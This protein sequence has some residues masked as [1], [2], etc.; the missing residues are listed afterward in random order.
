MG[1]SRGE[2]WWG[3]AVHKSASSY[4]PWLVVS[5]ESHPFAR[6]ECICLALTTKQHAQSISI[7]AEAW[8]RGGSQKDAFVSPWYA[9]T[10]KHRDFDNLQGELAANVVDAAHGALHDYTS[11]TE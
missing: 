9:T 2:V 6:T 3:P 10:M 1:V 11:G 7:P 8:V 5:D 4:R